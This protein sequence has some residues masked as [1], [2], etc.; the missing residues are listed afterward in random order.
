MH[1]LCAQ[2]RKV[3]AACWQPRR[4]APHSGPPPRRA[5]TSCRPCAPLLVLEVSFR[6]RPVSSPAVCVAPPL[7]RSRRSHDALSQASRRGHGPWRARASA[8]CAPVQYAIRVRRP[9]STDTP[10]VLCRQAPSARVS[11][12]TCVLPGPASPRVR[13][14]SPLGR[15][16]CATAIIERERSAPPR[17]RS[18]ATTAAGSWSTYRICTLSRSRTSACR[19]CRP[20]HRP[21][22][23]Q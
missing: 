15:K 22:Q 17:A 11:G 2:P 16:R 9:D 5:S 1:R 14:A 12:R 10:A 8:K 18:H 20:R 6:L 23:R 7:L 4:P 13:S 3:R 21:R 19:T